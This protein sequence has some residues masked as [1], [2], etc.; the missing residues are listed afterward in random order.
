MTERQG[1]GL[2]NRYARKGL[3]VR[4]PVPPPRVSAGRPVEI[5]T[6]VSKPR[7][8]A[9]CAH[10]PVAQRIRASHCG[11]EGQRFESSRAYRRKN[12]DL[13]VS[14]FPAV[15]SIGGLDFRVCGGEAAANSKL[16][17]EQP[18]LRVLSGVPVGRMSPFGDQAE[19][20]FVVG[21]YLFVIDDAVPSQRI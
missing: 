6:C 2:E 3:G 21:N 13:M 12:G 8:L 9:D 16:L 20:A 7:G 1:A 10:A 15:G 4:I 19:G 14:V 5:R 11:C 18:R 17:E